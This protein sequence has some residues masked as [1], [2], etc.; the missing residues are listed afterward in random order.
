[1]REATIF[2]I[3]LKAARVN[4][5]LKQSEAAEALGVDRATLHS[6]EAGKTIPQWDMVEKIE[7]LYGV[8][9]SNIFFGKQ[10]ALSEH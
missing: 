1:M 6:Y 7:S 4:A 9:A 10:L 2:R 3:S 5:G 8:S